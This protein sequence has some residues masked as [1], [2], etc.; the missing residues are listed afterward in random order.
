MKKVISILLGICL[1]IMPLT[2]SAA[3]EDENRDFLGEMY[4][5]AADNTPESLQYGKNLEALR[6]EKI[7]RIGSRLPKTDFFTVYH[8]DGSQIMLEIDK[9]CTKYS[10]YPDYMAKM[11]YYAN[12]GDAH[13]IELGSIIESRRNAK[14]N[15]DKVDQEKTYL[16]TEYAHDIATL[17]DKL[18]EYR[19]NGGKFKKEPVYPY[20]E[21]ELY[22][23][24]QIVMAEI[25]GANE[26]WAHEAVAGVMVNMV[27][28]PWRHP[29]IN[30]IS[31]VVNY[32]AFFGV[33]QSGAYKR[34][35]PT[36]YWLNLCRDTLENGTKIPKTVADFGGSPAGDAIWKVYSSPANGTDYFCHNWY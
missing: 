10:W 17:R 12:Q 29:G 26:R 6:N 19:A 1:L 28:H 11:Q 2:V 18:S 14:I 32:S 36:T 9:Y 35:S 5:C 23:M 3:S 31:D 21:E 30:S 15:M 24:A 27:D 20:T 4:E 33:L 34:Q 16:F 7:D 8:S 22:K 25:G 13:S